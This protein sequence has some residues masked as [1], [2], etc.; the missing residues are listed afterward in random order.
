MKQKSQQYMSQNEKRKNNVF[1]IFVASFQRL[2]VNDVQ[3]PR[4]R[5]GKYKMIC[6]VK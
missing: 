1:T 5:Q 6:R 3:S 4:T 2:C